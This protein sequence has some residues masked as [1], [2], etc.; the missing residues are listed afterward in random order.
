MALTQALL[1]G[2]FAVLVLGLM[3]LDLGILDR[4]AHAI[5]LKEALLRCAFF[6]AIAILFDLGVYAWLGRG[7]ALEFLTGYLIELSLSVDN[8]FVFLLIFSY[9]HVP[10]LHQPRILFWGILGALILRALFIA[11]GVT[12]IHKFHWVIYVF[13][14]FLVAT[15]IK[16]VFH[17]GAEIHPEKNPVLRLFKRFMAVTNDYEDGKFFLVRNGRALATP[18]FVVLLVIETTDLIFAVDSIPAVLAIT[19]DP[20]IVFTSNVFAILGLRALYFALAGLM[21]L[22]HYLHYGLAAILVFVGVKM[23]LADVYKMPIGIA[24]GVIAG[25]LLISVLASIVRPRMAGIV[26]PLTASQEKEMETDHAHHD[27]DLG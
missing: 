22:F 8:V 6:V 20:F 23:L 27:K 9:F 15:G 11:A 4:K 5:R 26:P 7:K 24:L 3:C 14:V 1:W 18:M 25:V 17:K 16:M 2:A 21:R 12:L 13:G 10:A 19:L